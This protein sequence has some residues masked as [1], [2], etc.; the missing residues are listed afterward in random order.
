MALYSTPKGS[1]HKRSHYLTQSLSHLSEQAGMTL[2]TIKDVSLGCSQ[3]VFNPDGNPIADIVEITMRSSTINGNTVDLQFYYDPYDWSFPPDLIIHGLPINPSLSDVG[4]DDSWD[5][6]D[7]ANLSKVLGKLSRM[8][9]HGERQ[10]VAMCDNERIQVEY[11]CLHEMEEME[12]C[13][14]PGVDGPTKVLFAVPFYIP[15]T[16]EGRKHRA[17]V[18]AKIQFLISSLMPND[19]T[20]VQ[21]N[22]EALSRLECPELLQSISEMGK[23]ESIVSFI[24][25]VSK[26][27]SEHFERLGRGRQMK[28][29]FIEVITATFRSQL[30]ECDVVDYTYASFL[31]TVPKDKS[32]G[33]AT[34]IATL[35]VPDDFP[36]EIPKLTLTAPVMPNNSYSPTPLA[37]VIPISR[38]SPRWDSNRIVDEIW[39]QL[40]D[41]IP[42]YHSKLSHPGTSSASLI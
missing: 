27:I 12:C 33:E 2:F 40:W 23:H 21:S 41:E 28:K 39:E 15:Y 5:Y 26:K 17:K 3:T 16:Y 1:Q 38:Y 14:I 29:E 6:N 24:E 25:R 13:L 11:S 18:V 36:N 30:L 22:I 19:V 42:R 7:P 34:A 20:A 35:Y 31:F 10:R 9:Q 8:M 4:L 32:R 37:E